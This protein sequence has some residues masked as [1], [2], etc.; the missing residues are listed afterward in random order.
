ETVPSGDRGHKWKPHWDRRHTERLFRFVHPNERWCIVFALDAYPHESVRL[1]RRVQLLGCIQSRGAT[2]LLPLALA[3][4]DGVAPN[5]PGFGLRIPAFFRPSVLH[6]WNSNG[7]ITHLQRVGQSSTRKQSAGRREGKPY[8]G[9]T[10]TRAVNYPFLLPSFPWGKE[11]ES[12]KPNF[13]GTELAV[14]SAH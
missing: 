10:P 8:G 9:A 14:V 1:L 3:L 13:R 4:N 6:G 7:V 5:R 11:A 12:Q 2:A